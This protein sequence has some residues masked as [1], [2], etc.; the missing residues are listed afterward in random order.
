[1][2]IIDLMMHLTTGYV[3]IWITAFIMKEELW[4]NT[5]V[6]TSTTD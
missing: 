3:T 4:I 5:C 2:E 1:M 6:K